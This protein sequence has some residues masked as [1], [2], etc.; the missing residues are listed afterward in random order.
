MNNSAHRLVDIFFYGLHM[1]A[2]SLQQKG[3]VIRQ[4]RLATIQHH[5]VVVR[6]KAMLLRERDALACGMLY[7]LTHAEIDL[8]YQHQTGYRAEAFLAN[9]GEREVCAISMVHIEPPID[10]AV[11]YAYVS[12]LRSV[13]ERLG[14]PVDHL[15]PL[16]A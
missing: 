14:F 4:P 8:L 11:D 6:E 5:S 15:P 3:I 7:Q 10:S 12:R 2:E 1:D 9:D 16:I 13:L